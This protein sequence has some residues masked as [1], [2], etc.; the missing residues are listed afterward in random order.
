MWKNPIFQERKKNVKKP[1][2]SGEKKKC[3]KPYLS[4]E[5]K[6]LKTKPL[7]VILRPFLEMC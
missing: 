4:G 6:N 7:T 1:Y 5:K 3:Q 2:F